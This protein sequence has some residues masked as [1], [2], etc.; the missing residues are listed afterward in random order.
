MISLQQS[1]VLSIDLQDSLLNLLPQPNGILDHCAWLYAVATR[2]QVPVLATLQYPEKLGLI[3]TGLENAI[4][5]DATYAKRSFSAWQDEPAQQEMIAT[6]KSQIIITGIETHVCVLQTCL[7]L[8]TANY[9][10]FIVRDAIQS[11]HPLDDTL[12]IERMRQAGAII[13]SKEMVFYEWL[14]SSQHPQFKQL[15]QDFIKPTQP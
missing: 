3:A 8:L 6:Q 10:V 1:L 12:A 11:R 2:L 15:N 9:H 14:R 4:L 13:V 7:D 5:P